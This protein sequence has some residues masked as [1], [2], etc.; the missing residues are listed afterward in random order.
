VGQKTVSFSDLS[1][2]IITTDDSV[3]RIVVHEHPELG[4]GP[5]EIEALL[6][7][8]RAIEKA[9][10]RVAVVDLYLPGDLPHRVTMDLGS[11]DEMATDKPMS[12]LLVAARPARRG[13]RAAAP[14]PARGDRTNYADLAHAGKPHKGKVTDAEKQ[15]VQE[16]FDE[17]NARLAREGIRTINLA[18]PEHVER[19]GL[20]EL[21]STHNPDVDGHNEDPDDD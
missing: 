6:D 2:E 7:E 16:N 15:L 21:A 10:L 11:F 5:V 13:S 14:A 20:E 9:A 3:A 17:I 19:Y 18:E 12:E 4:D 1:G 8:A